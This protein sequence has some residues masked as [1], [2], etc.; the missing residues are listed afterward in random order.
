MRRSCDIFS[1]VVRKPKSAGCADN[2]IF[3]ALF[4][5]LVDDKLQGPTLTGIG[6]FT[7]T[8]FN[9]SS[10]WRAI[11]CQLFTWEKTGD[12]KS[13]GILRG[14]LA[15]V[16]SW[17]S[18]FKKRFTVPLVNNSNSN[19]PF[20]CPPITP[21][22]ASSK[23][24]WKGHHRTQHPKAT[25]RASLTPPN[26]RPSLKRSGHTRRITTIHHRPPPNAHSP[27]LCRRNH[28]LDNPSGSSLHRTQAALFGQTHHTERLP[29][30][31]NLLLHHRNPY[32]G[33]NDIVQR[34][35]SKSDISNARTY[36]AVFGS[37]FGGE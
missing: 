29:W 20:R 6:G 14:V 31:D 33:P 17:L 32:P 25:N 30:H 35:T 4:L 27:A 12:D 28:H 21:Y 9:D 36:G 15:M 22:S 1:E 13:W 18:S 11:G 7:T 19:S 26:F 3:S 2:I 8:G 34:Q 37:Y 23:I 10:K 24:F 16:W 5:G